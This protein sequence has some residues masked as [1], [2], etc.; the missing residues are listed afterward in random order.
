MSD[1]NVLSDISSLLEGR[2][3]DGIAVCY[4]KKGID[5][6]IYRGYISDDSERLIS[7]NTIYDLAS[8]SKVLTT[9]T[10]LKMQ[11]KGLMSLEGTVGDY[12][13]EYPQIS[14]LKMYELLNFSK[15]L[16]TSGRVDTAGSREAALDCLKTTYIA[17]EIPAYNDIGPNVLSQ[18]ICEILNDEEGFEHYSEQ[19]W[20]EC[21][22]H[23]T[24]WWYKLPESKHAEAQCYDFEYRLVNSDITVKRTP[25]GMCHDGAAAA[26]KKA[27]GH[28]GVFSTPGDMAKLARNLLT[29]KVLSPESLDE[30]A[31]DKYASMSDKPQYYGL[32]CYRKNP[33]RNNSEIP[34]SCSERSIAI[35]GYSGTYL[36]LDFDRSSYCFI[37]SN[38]IYKRLTR[39]D[40]SCSIESIDSTFK[41]DIICDSSKYVFHKDKLVDDCIAD[42]MV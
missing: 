38:R 3:T 30:W 6:E 9:V 7:A 11:E 27:T 24:Y 12:S 28:A 15:N 18:I 39:D 22:M 21:G 20:K 42:L 29:G 35:S 40:R 32:G 41:K 33:D 36:L 1:T 17:S 34:A 23:S 4:G 5:N 25:K 14:H 8:V 10:A 2:F 16:R 26:L 19:I 13:A 31:S 37:G